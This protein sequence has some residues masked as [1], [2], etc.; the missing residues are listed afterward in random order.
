MPHNLEAEFQFRNRQFPLEDLFHVYET[1]DPS[2]LN[3]ECFMIHKENAKYYHGKNN[4]LMPT[5]FEFILAPKY[6][7][8]EDGPDKLNMVLFQQAME[9]FEAI[10]NHAMEK[11]KTA[12]PM[13]TSLKD[14]AIFRE[15]KLLVPVSLLDA[16]KIDSV[17]MANMYRKYVQEYN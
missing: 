12:S 9:L 8:W 16:D 5:R 10:L 3:R 17:H 6:E 2:I 1:P 13:S 4:N 15:L 7:K 14:P 11:H